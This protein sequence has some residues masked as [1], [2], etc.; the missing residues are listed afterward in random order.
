[1]ILN[2]YHVELGGIKGISQKYNIRKIPT[3]IIQ[4]NEKEILQIIENP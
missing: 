4:N 3:F 1:M 2:D